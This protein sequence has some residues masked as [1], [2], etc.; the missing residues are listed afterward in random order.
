MNSAS[1]LKKQRK[2]S[3]NLKTGKIEMITSEQQKEEK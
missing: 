3:A 1:D 2:E